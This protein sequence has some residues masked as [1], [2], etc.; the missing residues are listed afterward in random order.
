L[1]S[2]LGRLLV[3]SFDLIK[4]GLTEVRPGIRERFIFHQHQYCSNIFWQVFA[5]SL[6]VLWPF[7]F[8]DAH[9]INIETGQYTISDAF[10]QRINDINAW[11]M[12]RDIFD[13][14]PE[15]YSDIPAYPHL[16]KQI[17]YKPPVPVQALTRSA[18]NQDR[19]TSKA[20]EGLDV[21]QSC[22]GIST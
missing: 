11:T 22:I 5:S 15:F 6:R 3:I 19:H 9:T 13:R 4:Q 14:W 16:N 1:T 8:R 2:S 12:T 20:L 10:D 17:S 7:E 21:M 18:E